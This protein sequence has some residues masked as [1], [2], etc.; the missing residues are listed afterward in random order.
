[1][2]RETCIIFVDDSNV[3]IEAQKHA[4]SGK[5]HLP[6]L[7]GTD[8]DPRARIDIGALLE[9]LRKNRIQGPSFL[10]GSRPPPNDTVW[11]A[12]ENKMFKTCI[13]DRNKKNKEKQVDIQMSVDMTEKALE[14]KLSAK[15][16]DR[17]AIEERDNT[18]FVVITGD[19]D[20]RPAVEKII[21]CG[22]RVE[23]WAWKSNISGEYVT[24]RSKRP[25]LFFVN[26]LDSIY[27]DISF[28][29]YRST[30]NGVIGGKTIVLCEI[31][32]KDEKAVCD[33]L[34]G[35]RQLFYTT[36]FEGE[37]ECDLCVELPNV[38]QIEKV[39]RVAE[40]LLPNVKILSWPVWRTWCNKPKDYW[41]KSRTLNRY[42]ISEKPQSASINS[43]S[44]PIEPQPGKIDVS[45][46]PLLHAG[47]PIVQ[48]MQDVTLAQETDEKTKDQHTLSRTADNTDPNDDGNSSSGEGWTTY[49]NKR[50]DP[51]KRHRRAVN[52]YQDCPYGLNCNKKEYC[53]KRHTVA[54]DRIFRQNANQ[55][56]VNLSMRKT[57]MCDYFPNCNRGRDCAFAHSEAEAR[58]LDC[59]QTGHFKGNKNKCTLYVGGP[60][61]K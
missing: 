44:V 19:L 21:E 22:I 57:K 37:L 6:K 30:R 11:R 24:L 16:G 25:D 38:D 36:R 60:T 17:K 9:K 43:S 18:V 52:Q 27:H 1:M 55:K 13:F 12:F 8:R 51:G 46:R 53:S 40:G 32:K 23:L 26:M 7:N 14:L 42:R 58:C 50:N 31:D 4:A 49:V 41:E 61:G 35:T 2:S 45:T 39:L 48:Q 5:S 29:A 34:L 59:K 47:V 28:T 10:Y 54:E 15:N 56:S 20:M 33:Q 3:W